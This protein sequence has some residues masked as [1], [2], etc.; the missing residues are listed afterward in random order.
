MGGRALHVCLTRDLQLGPSHHQSCGPQYP[1][2]VLREVPGR[3]PTP[4]GW[5]FLLSPLILPVRRARPVSRGAWTQ[6][7][8]LGWADGRQIPCP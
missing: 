5:S 6:A 3:R 2:P 7:S 4:K 1:S 8:L